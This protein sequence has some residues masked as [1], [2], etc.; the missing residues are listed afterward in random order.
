MILERFT[1][2]L[3]VY[4]GRIERWP[5]EE[6]HAAR[7]LLARSADA[8]ARAAAAERLDALLDQVP[9]PAPS[10][11]LV[12]RV[13]AA[14]PARA[15][16]RTLPTRRP[17]RVLITVGGG[18]AVAASLALWLLRSPAPGTPLGASAIAQLGVLDMPTDVLLSD[19]DLDLG[20]EFPAFG[21]DD[22]ALGCD[23]ATFEPMERSGH[24]SNLKEMP[25]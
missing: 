8:R 5:A 22:P 20:N 10:A 2:L 18:A 7:A 11:A 9:E 14:A 13:L 4:G 12:T 25:A 16:V 15:A 21:C 1:N 24:L 3:D 19:A 23:D 6:R 17:W